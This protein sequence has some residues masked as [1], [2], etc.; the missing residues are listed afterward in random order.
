[1]DPRRVRGGLWPGPGRA[2]PEPAPRRPAGL[3]RPFRAPSQVA[4]GFPHL[5]YAFLVRLRPLFPSIM[6]LATL[7]LSIALAGCESGGVSRTVQMAER[8]VWSAG[9]SWT[10]RGRG[11][12]G[13]YNVTRTVLR[14]GVFEGREAY[15]IEAGDTHYWYTKQLGYLARTK[16]DQT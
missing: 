2:L 10:Y 6:L 3:S 1:G 16:G 4:G 13:T 11:P 12:N 5:R 14:E 9:D 7:A 15:E 8:P